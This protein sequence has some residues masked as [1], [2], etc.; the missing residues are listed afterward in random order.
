MGYLRTISKNN[1]GL[2]LFLMM[3]F[4]NADEVGAA[5]TAVPDCGSIGYTENSCSEGGIRCPFDTS[6]MLCLESPKNLALEF[7]KSLGYEAAGFTADCKSWVDTMERSGVPCSSIKDSNVL[8]FK[9]DINKLTGLLENCRFDC[10]AVCSTAGL[11][12]T[13]NDQYGECK[14]ILVQ[15]G[16]CICFK[17]TCYSPYTVSADKTKCELRSGYCASIGLSDKPIM[18]LSCSKEV[19]DCW[20]CR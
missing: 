13:C 2:G 12:H 3:G 16:A 4:I 1:V 14:S 5:C 8:G 19:F 7:C 11:P 15:G 17:L 20:R 6:K 9:Y 10:N 18:G